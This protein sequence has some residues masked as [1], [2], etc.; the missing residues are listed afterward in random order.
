MCARV[1]PRVIPLINARASAFQ[2]GEPRP[3]NAGTKETPPVDSTVRASRS[4]S[5]ASPRM[6]SSSRNHWIAAPLAR[7]APSSA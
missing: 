7:I 2:C 4:L 5:A 3:A 1:V 6:P